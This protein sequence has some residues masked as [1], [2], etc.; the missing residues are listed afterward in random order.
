[1][2]EFGDG[3]SLEPDSPR[4]GERSEKDSIASEDH[5]LDAGNRR[6]LER[7]A[8]LKGA[9]MAGMNPQSFSGLQIAND[10]LAG[11]FQPGSSLSS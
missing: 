4:P 6:D 5:V 11:E 10:Q 1:M 9:D 8:G 3:Q 7:D 2:R